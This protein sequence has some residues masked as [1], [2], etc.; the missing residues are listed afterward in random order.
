MSFEIAPEAPA[1]GPAL[2]GVL[3]RAFGPGRFAKTSE[4]VRELGPVFRADLSRVALKEGRPIG[5]CR[6]FEVYAGAAPALFLGPLAVDPAAQ[7][8][9]V[10][11]ALIAETIKACRETAFGLVLV[12]GTPAR[13]QP[14]GFSQAPEGQIL[15][16]GPTVWA[17]F[18]ALE[19]QPGALAAAKGAVAARPP[20]SALVAQGPGA[21][22]I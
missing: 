5:C 6:I 13:F 11:K 4:R 17:R 15:L 19:L 1:H 18:Q 2:E 9:G 14:H 8:E 12:V 21:H 7:G 22:H 16:P 20:L 10:A 3:N